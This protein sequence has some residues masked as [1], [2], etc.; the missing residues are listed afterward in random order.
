ME[1]VSAG[2]ASAIDSALRVFRKD[3]PQSLEA[4]RALL[5]EG[6]T[7]P[8]P[9]AVEAAL[10]LDRADRRLIQEGLLAAGF[11]PGASDGQFGAGTRGALR[12][13]QAA[14]QAAETGYLDAASALRL[15]AEGAARETARRQA[16]VGSSSERPG[17]RGS[18]REVGVT[19]GGAAAAVVWGGYPRRWWLVGASAA[20]L[21]GV[22][23]V[24]A[25]GVPW[26]GVGVD[27]VFRD[28]AECPEMVVLPGG[29]L[30]MGRYEVTV[31][32]YRAFASATG[33]GSGSGCSAQNP[34]G[35]RLERRR[36]V[37]RWRA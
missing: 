33:G 10:G 30:A 28:C 22:V 16:E 11:D 14:R 32:E 13:W 34:T 27:D 31:G 15:T 24:A 4:W 26:N 25:L 7:G 12:E 2:L 1:P 35:F 36:T 18:P 19:A 5:E 21:A 20:L 37:I 29:G 3:R 9:S 23:L 17:V 8:S 6:A